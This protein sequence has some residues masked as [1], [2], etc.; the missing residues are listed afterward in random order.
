[1][2]N[3]LPLHRFLYFQH[4]MRSAFGKGHHNGRFHHPLRLARDY[5]TGLALYDC[6]RPAMRAGRLTAQGRESEFSGSSS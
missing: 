5:T 2:G 4:D 3:G 6:F 1:M